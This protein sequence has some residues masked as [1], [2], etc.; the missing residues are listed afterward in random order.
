MKNYERK[1]AW[2]KAVREG[3]IS[4]DQN[5][6]MWV[7][8]H[9]VIC[10]LTR[11]GGMPILRNGNYDAVNSYLA[12]ALADA[13][14][15][16]EVLIYTTRVI[17][18]TL[19]RWL[20]H[21]LSSDP[22]DRDTE[23]GSVTVITMGQYPKKPL[24]FQVNVVEP[25]T[26][27]ASAVFDVI[28]QKS[29]NNA[30]SQ[31][32]VEAD[33]T[34]YRLEPVRNMVGKIIDCTKYGYVVRSP[35]GHVFLASMISRRIQSQLKHYN[36]R[37]DDL[38]DTE[39]KI[40]YTMFTEGN[41][42]CNYKSTII[43]RSFALDNMGGSY[44]STYDG[45]IPFDSKPGGANLSL[46]TV[47]RC[48]RAAIEMRNGVIYG[49]DHESGEALY[50]FEPGA[51]RGLYA[52]QFEHQGKTETWRFMSEFSVDALDPAALVESISTQIFGATGYSLQKIGL[53]YAE[54]E[55]ESLEA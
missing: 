41:R 4:R 17:P 32:I 55:T 34:S 27:K 26:M 6:K 52:A 16:G 54:H 21:W 49:I 5:V 14:I 31:F 46:L 12:R 7:L 50:S 37:L 48:R 3:T 45:P 35:S 44:P 1:A 47:T 30:I 15:S 36:V 19:S 10:E 40:E 2:H 53:W 8:P 9:G 39:V 25:V 42:L 29:I 43:Y 24:P 38:I 23:L 28:K 51:E 33:E 18:Q 20:T 13:G 22:D 11:V